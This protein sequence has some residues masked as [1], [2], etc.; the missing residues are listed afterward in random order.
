MK[1]SKMEL[2]A[3]ASRIKKDLNA[4]ADQAQ[5]ALDEIS[6]KTNV[7]AAKALFKEIEAIS[8]AA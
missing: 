5:K 4:A 1:L 2:G 3:L 6:D 7:K 8:P